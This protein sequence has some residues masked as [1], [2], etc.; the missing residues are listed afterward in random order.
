LDFNESKLNE[1]IDA[2]LVGKADYEFGDN[3]FN[4]S[5]N[6]TAS[7]FIGDGSLLTGVGGHF[8]G[9]S[10][11]SYNGGLSAGGYTGYRAGNYLCD[12]DIAGSHLCSFAEID[13]TIGTRNLSAISGWTGEAWISTGPAK[14]SPANLPANDC[15][16]F[17]HGSLGDYLG[18]WWSFDTGTGG[19]GKTGHCGNTLR[20][21][22]CI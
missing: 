18:N 8:V 16:G 15:N 7:Y 11:S 5:G 2:K 12:S 9:R 13:Y 20:L 22:C 14:Y 4:G 10:T 3:D 1:S 21:A 17:T 19:V 6:V